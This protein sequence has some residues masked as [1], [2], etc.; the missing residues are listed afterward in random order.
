VIG[1]DL[2]AN[3]TALRHRLVDG[4]LNGSGGEFPVLGHVLP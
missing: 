3:L 2:N 1:G 4:L